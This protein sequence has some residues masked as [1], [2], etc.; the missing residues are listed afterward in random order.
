MYVA[1]V[2]SR[3][4]KRE[5]GDWEGGGSGCTLSKKKRS[6]QHS[7]IVMETNTG[8]RSPKPEGDVAFIVRAT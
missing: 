3:D 2:E 1:G 7:L 5:K 8:M 4:S 6:H